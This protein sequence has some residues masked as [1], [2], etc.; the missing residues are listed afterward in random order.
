MREFTMGR[1]VLTV[2]LSAGSFFLCT[3]GPLFGAEAEAAKLAYEQ[4]NALERS[5]KWLEAVEAYRKIIEQ[6]PNTA[7]KLSARRQLAGAQAALG[8]TQEAYQTYVTYIQEDLAAANTLAAKRPSLDTIR[9]QA[10]WKVARALLG[11]NRPDKHA[12]AKEQF[13]MLVRDFPDSPLAPEALRKTEWLNTI[14][15]ERARR[16][17]E[18][19]AI[20]TVIDAYANALKEKEAAGALA[21][22]AAPPGDDRLGNDLRNYFNSAGYRAYRYTVKRV[23]FNGDMTK[24]TVLTDALAPNEEAASKLFRLVRTA[25]GWKLERL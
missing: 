6:Y 22:L 13:G 7:I 10:R 9:A 24:A 5:G 19:G 23:R 2:V 16:A 18:K 14:M 25:E 20:R 3:R 8:K 11:S 4:A 21:L 1:M 12:S 15:E 17:Q